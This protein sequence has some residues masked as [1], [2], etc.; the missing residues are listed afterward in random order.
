MKNLLMAAGAVFATTAFLAPAF[1]AEQPE[2][3]TP[4]FKLLYDETLTTENV[5]PLPAHGLKIG[6]TEVQL[7]LTSLTD[8][9]KTYGG[10]I[11]DFNGE[12]RGKSWLCYALPANATAP[13]SL[14]W[15][16]SDGVMGNNYGINFV[17]VEVAPAGDT[18]TCV[19]PTTPLVLTSTL[20][21]L[22]APVADV[23]KAIPGLDAKD[24]GVLSYGGEIPVPAYLKFE[25]EAATGSVI[26]Y[27]I[28]KGVVTI[29]TISQVSAM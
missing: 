20:P 18:P 4:G 14:A 23:V 6:E 13:A 22:G 3:A 9:Q 8:L 28:T 17:V 2:P 15:F 25:G 10:E 27:Q 24:D 29:R 7:E 11:S 12:N 21:S 1:A 19:A 26:N 5:E 16:V